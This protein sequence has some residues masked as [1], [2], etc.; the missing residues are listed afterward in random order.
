MADGSHQSRENL[1]D[2]VALVKTDS[3]MGWF[4][5]KVRSPKKRVDNFINAFAAL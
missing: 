1:T 2:D 5:S 3:G 4:D